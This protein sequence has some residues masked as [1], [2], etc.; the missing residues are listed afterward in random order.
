MV[1]GEQK[2]AEEIAVR[3]EKMLAGTLEASIVVPVNQAIPARQKV[4]TGDQ[5]RKLLD[6][7]GPIAITGCGCRATLGNCDASLDVCIILGLTAEM[8]ADEESY[9]VVTREEAMDILDRTAEM[10]LV[11]LT[12]WEEGHTP[13][14]VCSCCSC[15]CHEL[16]AMSRFGYNDQV[17][18]SDFIAEHDAGTCLGCGTCVSRCNFGAFAECDTGVE[19]SSEMCFGCGVCVTACPERA[20]SLVERG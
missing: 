11:H 12:M 16:L 18:A 3:R 1:D 8:M 6:E 4:L 20:I 19:F 13:Y 10:G 15:C 17:I 9:T 5:V 7:H 2:M 14:A